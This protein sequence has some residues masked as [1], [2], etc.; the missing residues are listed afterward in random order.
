MLLCLKPNK[1][2]LKMKKFY[3]YKITC[4]FDELNIYTSEKEGT[5]VR[6]LK[7]KTNVYSE[8]HDNK[9]LFFV[10][11]NELDKV[12]FFQYFDKYNKNCYYE[13]YGMIEY[14]ESEEFKKHEIQDKV[15][16]ELRKNIKEKLNE[17]KRFIGQYE[18]LVGGAIAVLS[19]DV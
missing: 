4:D 3:E 9:N 11:K 2:E 12:R 6:E 14:E 5:F 1:K 8:T 13:A 16:T 15:K 17:I 7:D 19:I 10:S 18:E